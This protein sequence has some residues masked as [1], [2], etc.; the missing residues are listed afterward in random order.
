MSVTTRTKEFLIQELSIDTKFGKVDISSVFE[1]LNIFDNI[2]QP[3]ISGNIAIRDALSLISKLSLDGSEKLN[4]DIVKNEDSSDIEPLRYKKTFSI[5]KLSDRKNVNQTSEIYIFHFVSEEFI[6]SEQQRINRAYQNDY[7]SIVV[8][9]L[10]NNLKVPLDSFYGDFE[11]SYG[12][13]KIVVPNLTPL[14][15][16]SWCAKRAI[17]SENAGLLPNFLFF[18]NKLGYNFVKLSTLLSRDS[19]FNVT[20]GPKNILNTTQ[21]EYF[22]ASNLKVFKQFDTIESIQSGLYS[23]SFIGFDPVTRTIGKLNFSYGDLFKRS[24]HANLNPNIAA[25]KNR[26][27]KYN[28]EMNQSRKSLYTF[29]V[30]QSDSNYIKINDPYS[31]ATNNDTQNYIFLRKAIFAG[32]FQKRVKMTLPGNFT[33]SSGL[34]LNLDVPNRALAEVSGDQ[35]DKSLNGKYLISSTR[36]MIKYNKHETIVEVCTDSSTRKALIT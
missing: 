26:L 14:D 5:Y 8:D 2:F 13:K 33:V 7:S 6:L 20:F 15:T 21:S 29:N 28:F 16:I 17:S 24:S 23:G 9:I 36:H 3:C 12:I 10:I 31:L 22:A 1:E 27:N 30:F 19:L 11:F 18:E 4:I 35:D 32:L 34:N 25:F